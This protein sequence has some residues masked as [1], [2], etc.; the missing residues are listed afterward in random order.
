MLFR[1]SAIPITGRMRTSTAEP[2]AGELSGESGADV[3]AQLRKIGLQPIEVKPIHATRPGD[4]GI[5]ALWA[6]HL[7]TR[8]RPLRAEFFDSLATLLESG[9]PLLES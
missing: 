1:Y 5:G 2:V 7:R 8:R 9:M 3:R 4:R 6:S